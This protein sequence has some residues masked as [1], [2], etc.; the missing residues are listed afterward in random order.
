MMIEVTRCR[1]NF[2]LFLSVNRAFSSEHF[3]LRRVILYFRLTLRLKIL[4]LLDKTIPKSLDTSGGTEEL[5]VKWLII[6]RYTNC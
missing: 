4:K 3:I 2:F 5:I 1:I 6:N